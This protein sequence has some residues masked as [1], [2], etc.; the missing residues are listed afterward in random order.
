[1]NEQETTNV[2]NEVTQEN[3]YQYYIDVIKDY[4]TNYVPKARFD[5]L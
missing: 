3:D 4:Q 5:K 1:M 2:T